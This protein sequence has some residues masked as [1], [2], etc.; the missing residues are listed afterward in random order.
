MR[1]ASTLTWISGV[2]FAITSFSRSTGKTT[3]NVYLPSSIVRSMSLRWMISTGRKSGGWNASDRRCESWDW[4]SSTT[5]M[6][7]SA[8]SVEALDATMMAAV[9]E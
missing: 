6:A 4:S 3:T 8:K 9:K 2:M 7:A 1:V 5:A